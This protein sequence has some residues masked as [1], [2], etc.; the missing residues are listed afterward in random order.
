MATV[1][2][3]L[4]RRRLLFAAILFGAT[5]AL[6]AAIVLLPGRRFPA[7]GCLE[8]RGAAGRLRGGQ[9]LRQ[10]A[11]QSL[12]G[13]SDRRAHA[14]DRP[15][16]GRRRSGHPRVGFCVQRLQLRLPRWI[17]HRRGDRRVRAAGDARQCLRRHRDPDRQA[18]SRR[19]LDLGRRLRRRGRRGDLA[20]DEDPHEG[21]QLWSS[22][23]TTSSPASRST[24]TRSRRRRRGSRSRSARPTTSRPTTSGRP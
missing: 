14:G 5:I 20:R 6:H 8:N 23:R 2:N 18:V 4:I 13:R 21:R 15:G 16:R 11:L 1:R 10:P 19:A 3:R 12:G 24:T 22:C 17:R 7:P 9:R